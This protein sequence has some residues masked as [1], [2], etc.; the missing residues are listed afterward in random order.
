MHLSRPL[1]VRCAVLGILIAGF[2]GADF[3]LPF[4][5]PRH[6]PD[7]LGAVLLGNYIGQINL[8]AVWAVL[9]RGTSSCGCP[10]RDCWAR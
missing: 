6:R 5:F 1:L 9:C 4:F 8:I 7:M 10:G 3:A 2:L